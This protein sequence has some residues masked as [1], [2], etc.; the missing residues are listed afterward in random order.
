[1]RNF[2]YYLVQK[3][4]LMAVTFTAALL[5]LRI[6]AKAVHCARKISFVPYI[7]Y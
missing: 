5:I 4:S 6:N 7:E 3:E 1:M 2:P